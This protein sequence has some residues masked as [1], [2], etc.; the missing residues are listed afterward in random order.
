[1]LG[2]PLMHEGEPIG[3]IGLSR[4][5]LDPFARREVELV[6][7]FAAQAVIAIENARLFE[8]EQQR[9]RELRESLEQQTATSE[10]LGVISSSPGNLVPVFETM[11]M[12]AIKLCEASFGVLWRYEQGRFYATTS[13]GVPQ[14]F[15][16]FLEKPMQP[17][18]GGAFTQIITGETV[19]QLVDIANS[20]P[21][22]SGASALRRA[23]FDLAGAQTVLFVALRKDDVLVG[24]LSI[25]RREI[26]P[27]TDKQIALVQNFAAQ[28]VIAIENTRL[29]NELR[30]RTEDLTEFLEQQTATSDVLQVISSSRGELEPVFQ[31]ILENATRLCEA[32]MGDL[33]LCEGTD[34]LRMVAMHG[35]PAEWIDYRRQ[36]PDIRPGPNTASGRIL[37]DKQIVHIADIR[38][39]GPASTDLFRKAFAAIVGARTLLAVPMLKDDELIGQITVYRQEVRPFGEKQIDLVKNFAAQAVIA[40]ENTRLLNELRESLEQQTATAEVLSVISSSPGE[41]KPVFESMLENAVRI[42][43]ARFGNLQ[44]FDG[45][46]MRIV[47]MHNA[48][49]EFAEL[50][51]DNPVVPLYRSILGPLVKTKKVIHVADLAAEEPFASSTLATLAGARTALAV[52]MLREGELV[53]G[54]AIYHQEVRPFTEKQIELL[55]NFAAQAVIAIENTRLLNELR[56]SL[57]QQT[58]TSEVLGIISSSPGELEPVFGAMLANATKLCDA[59]YGT[60]WLHEGHGQM[61]AAALH[62]RLPEAFLEK[63]GVGTE[64]CPSPAQPSARAMHSRKPVQL[65]DLMEDQSYIDGDALA[66]AAVQV[67]GVRSVISV[68]MVKDDVTVGTMTIYRREVRPFTDKQIALV[69]NF[70]A[71]AVIAIENSRLLN[72]LRQRTDDL[73][74]SLEQQT[75][76]SEVLRVISSSPGQLEPVFQAMLENAA[77]ICDASFGFMFRTENSEIAANLGVPKKFLDALESHAHHPGSL[78]A[79]ARLI[80]SRQTIHIADYSADEAYLS[81]DPLA[82][83]GVELGGVRTLLNVPM[84][85]DGELIGL[86]GLFRQEVRPFTDKAD[87][88]RPEFCRPGRHR[89]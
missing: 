34:G 20:E 58:A 53:G 56:E 44:L 36:H 74:E 35:A 48:P 72:E 26:R 6:S 14:Q 70:A 16:E 7:T 59:S 57:E 83:I 8:A 38:D 21:Y 61:R 17:T 50:R 11:L 25:Y 31:T 4:N 13:H 66:V 62:G 82:T 64:Y 73:M 23:F 33:Q 3:V 63:W 49:R 51:R 71:Q 45:K 54:I 68:P 79:S 85:K 1:M 81:R 43:S 40:I 18:P 9:T 76:T 41:L 77:R 87:R 89:H 80:K 39:D 75:A 29:L 52:P 28:A 5:R 67:A 27:F 24:V 46:D 42:C 84:I 65:A 2:V 78:S 60:L 47:A 19:V 69:T 37:R 22:R 88:A 30:Q 10:V 15:A 32:R 12:Q 55:T 86:I